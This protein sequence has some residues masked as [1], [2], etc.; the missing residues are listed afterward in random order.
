MIGLGYVL[1]RITTHSDVIR[2]QVIVQCFF[3]AEVPVKLQTIVHFKFVCLDSTIVQGVDKLE[4]QT[5]STQSLFLTLRQNFI[6]S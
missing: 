5:G 2:F 3:V 6:E 1:E 4:R